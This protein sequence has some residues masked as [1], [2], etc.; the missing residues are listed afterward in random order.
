[1]ADISGVLWWRH[2]RGAPTQ[3]VIHVVRGKVRHEGTGVS[4]WFRPLTAVLSELPVDDRELQLLFHARTADFTDVTVQAAVTYRI[5]QPA[6]AAARLDFSVDP[7]SGMARTNPLDQLADPL[8]ELAQQ[9]ALD[10]L[11]ALPLTEAITGAVGRIRDAIAGALGSDEWLHATG[12]EVVAVRVVAVRPEAELER[13]L[14]TPTRESVQAEADRARYQRRA[15][16]VEHERA[17]AEN[18][19]QSR[20]ELARREEQLVEQ[21]SA[22]SRRRAQEKAETARI[23]VAADAE[24]KRTL[25]AAEADRQRTLPT[26]EADQQ[27]VLGA[28]EADRQRA[29]TAA[30]ADR[31]RAL[32]ESKAVATRAVG[33]AEAEAEHALLAVRAEIE[34]CSTACPPT[35]ATRGGGT[36]WSRCEHSRPARRARHPAKRARRAAGAARHTQGRRV[37]PQGP[38]P[39]PRQRAAQPRRARRGGPDRQRGHPHRLAPGPRRAR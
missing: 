20:I 31:Q 7:V 30:E 35:K 14:Q 36:T 27:R 1:M 25:A 5:A 9:P 32:G 24:R 12:I 18:E 4:F 3:H 28:A 10:L 13:A 2:L 38:G 21:E 34:R 39:R 23:E 6:T 11:A 8:T 19:L 16:A 22:N 33:A 17:I 29:L 15:T 37:L 26:A